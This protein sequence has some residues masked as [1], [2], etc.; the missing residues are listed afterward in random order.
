MNHVHNC[1]NKFVLLHFR[2]VL[3]FFQIAR[4][5][6]VPIELPSTI[7]I[8]NVCDVSFMCRFGNK[9]E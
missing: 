5:L 6:L 3:Y 4:S 1:T 2:S 7:K 9:R 8:R